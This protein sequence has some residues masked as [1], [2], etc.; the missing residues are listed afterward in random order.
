MS[1]KVSF[2]AIILLLIASIL[3]ITPLRYSHAEN[4]NIILAWDGIGE[5]G[6]SSTYSKPS[7]DDSFNRTVKG[8]GVEA[9]LTFAFVMGGLAAA[10]LGFIAGGPVGAA[11]GVGAFAAIGLS[12][13]LSD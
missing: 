12:G 3:N 11:I 10:G 2:P 9:G 6:G 7:S 1:Q 8:V 13:F 4:N 5:S